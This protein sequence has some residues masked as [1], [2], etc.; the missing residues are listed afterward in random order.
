MAFIE[1]PSGFADYRPP[2]R[3]TNTRAPVAPAPAP[4]PATLNDIPG[5]GVITFPVNGVGMEAIQGVIGQ[6]RGSS[7][8][9]RSHQGIDIF[10]PQGANVFAA[11]AGEIIKVGENGLGGMRVSVEDPQGNIHYYAHLSGFAEGIVARNGDTPGTMVSSGALLGYV[12]T[13]GN[14]KGTNP[15]L[16][17]SINENRDN[18]VDPVQLFKSNQITYVDRQEVPGGATSNHEV[19]GGGDSDLDQLIAE[20]WPNGDIPEDVQ[21]S[22]LPPELQDAVSKA[23]GYVTTYIQHPELGPILIRGGLL[24]QAEDLILNAIKQTNWWAQT[25]VIR[26]Q[27]E[28][29]K[30]TDE[31]EANRQR[32]AR[33]AVLRD[34]AGKAGVDLLPSQLETLVEESLSLG[35]NEAQIIDAIVS[36]DQFD[37]N[38]E[39]PQALGDLRTITENIK[40]MA[41]RYMLTYSPT[42][43]Q[44]LSRRIVAGELEEDDLRSQFISD[45]K[46]RFPHFSDQLDKGYTITQL[47]D[48]RANEVGR[49]LG[50]D[51]E[52][53]DFLDD[54]RFQSILEYDDGTGEGIRS[55]NLMETRRHLATLPEYENTADAHARGSSLA[56]TLLKKFGAI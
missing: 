34:A 35:W 52:E 47:M 29:L 55:M 19:T 37:P 50:I 8:N 36:E 41:S 23:L 38:G 21:W 53:V 27:W 28:G 18:L 13:T 33:G 48:T 30:I 16:H 17:Y 25:D 20:N 15:H 7:A 22:D 2:K 39:D 26:R 49:I 10:A 31:G 56:N 46:G 24:E 40:M 45:A 42:V 4:R 9:P 44:E 54:P 51:A 1:D 3:T 43:Q 12:G 5:I 32:L 14:A 6:P 11:T